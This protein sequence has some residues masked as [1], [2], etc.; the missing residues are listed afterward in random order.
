MNPSTVVFAVTEPFA[1]QTQRALTTGT[2]ALYF[3]LIMLLA[4]ILVPI[5]CLIHHAFKKGF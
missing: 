5:G 1:L 3:V 4:I 2:V